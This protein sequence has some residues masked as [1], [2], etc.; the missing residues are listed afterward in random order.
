MNWKYIGCGIAVLALVGGCS[1]ADTTGSATD[2]E[3]NIYITAD[4][5]STLYLYAP[6]KITASTSQA[7]DQVTDN[8]PST[9]TSPEVALGYNGST[10]S[11]ATEGA[12]VAMEAIKSVMETNITDTKTSTSEQATNHAPAVKVTPDGPLALT[13]QT[14]TEK[15]AM[16]P[17]MGKSFTWL[18][19]TGADYGGPMKITFNNGCGSI[20]VPDAK[21]SIKH[22]Y[23]EKVYF[24]GTDFE[25][26]SKENLNNRASVFTAV[27]C[28]ATEVTLE[29]VK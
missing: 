29:Y 4:N 20:D 22:N 14:V 27:G 28:V 23:N 9:T 15:H 5:G 2:K 24:C 13:G 7:T 8:D 1:T 11:L 26:G 3:N 21:V 6:T 10:A 19:K 18:E 17:L 12:K 25:V 16:E